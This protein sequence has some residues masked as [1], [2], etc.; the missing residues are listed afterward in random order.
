MNKVKRFDDGTSQ[1]SNMST[2]RADAQQSGT[3]TDDNEQSMDTKGSATAWGK[4]RCRNAKQ[5]RLLKV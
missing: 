5:Q 4:P 2:A 1:S 3:A